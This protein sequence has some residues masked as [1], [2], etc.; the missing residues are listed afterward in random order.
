MRK[1]LSIALLLL[2]I[3]AFAAPLSTTVQG[4]GQQFTIFLYAA[5]FVCGKTSDKGILS[6][7]T[8]E[9]VINVH[10]PSPIKKTVYIKR[11]SL[12]LPGEKPGKISE[13]FGGSLGPDESMS[14]ECDNIYKH[15]GTASG[16]FIDGFALLYSPTELDVV[17]VYTAGS[18]EVQT[19]HT[20]RVPV[21]K[22]VLPIASA[23]SR[24][25][26]EQQ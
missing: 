16:S 13:F 24:R 22:L 19:L 23:L 6:P 3:A 8:Y 26:R 5:K 17:S 25:M 1:P 10:N 15:T 9:T 11:F 2:V 18:N 14:I 20:E 12:A 21:R 4:Q 7:G